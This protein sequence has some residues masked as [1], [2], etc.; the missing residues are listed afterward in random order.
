MEILM[1]S[2]ATPLLHIAKQ[3]IIYQLLH[4]G[5]ILTSQ[6]ASFTAGTHR[7]YCNS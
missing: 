5:Y 3:L 1:Q 6:I 2:A 7:I 4:A